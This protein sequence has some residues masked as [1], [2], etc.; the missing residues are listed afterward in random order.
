M[1]FAFAVSGNKEVPVRGETP[2]FITI[3][4]NVKVC[5]STQTSTQFD[6]LSKGTV[7]VWENMYSSSGWVKI[8]YYKN[9]TGSRIVGYIPGT[10][11]CPYGEC[12]Y[13]TAQS[14]LHLRESATTDSDSLAVIPYNTFV[15]IHSGTFT[16]GWGRCTVLEGTYALLSGYVSQ[17]YVSQYNG[18]YN[19]WT[20]Q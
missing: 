8:A 9:G 5:K 7:V 13:T 19:W 20:N 12:F 14:G 6:T 11:V 16:N 4:D 17:S 1:P 10:Q 15:Q 18:V 3:E 2:R